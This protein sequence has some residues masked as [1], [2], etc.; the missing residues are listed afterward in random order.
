MSNPAL[1][2]LLREYEQK[3][4]R[5]E[6]IFEKEK[7]A[8]Y[9]AHPELDTLNTKLG[10]TALDISKAILQQNTDL[11]DKLKIEYAN[12]EKE[13]QEMLKNIDIPIRSSKAYI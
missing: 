2:N 7:N 1:K 13:K 3:K 5:A 11:A 8:F 10:K 12:L 4:Y 9:Q 6:L